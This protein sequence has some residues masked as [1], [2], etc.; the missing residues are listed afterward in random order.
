MNNDERRRIA[1]WSFS[2]LLEALVFSASNGIF[3]DVT[4][5]VW[6]ASSVWEDDNFLG[7]NGWR[8]FVEALQVFKKNRY[9]SRAANDVERSRQ[10]GVSDRFFDDPSSSGNIGS[11]ISSHLKDV[12]NLQKFAVA[13]WSRIMIRIDVEPLEQE[14]RGR[15]KLLGTQYNALQ[16]GWVDMGH[17]V[18]GRC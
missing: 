8:E 9:R 15:L 10:K 18:G 16:S 2:Q 4:A 17:K 3:E 5:S 13:Y 1:S 6:L 14:T 12:D 11:W 7:M